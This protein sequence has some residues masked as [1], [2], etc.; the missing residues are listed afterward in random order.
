MTAP[1]VIFS[2]EIRAESNVEQVRLEIGGSDLPKGPITWGGTLRKNITRYAGDDQ[3][4]AQILGTIDEPFTLEGVFDDYWWGAIGH[5]REMKALCEKL[6]YAGALVHLEYRDEQR[7]GLFWCRLEEE[8]PERISYTI[9]FEPLYRKAPTQ[10]PLSFDLPPSDAA[11]VIESQLADMLD[12]AQNSNDATNVAAVIAGQVVSKMLEAEGQIGAALD[13]VSQVSYWSE[14]GPDLARQAR[15][16][17]SG[18]VRALGSAARRLG[19]TT[20]T[21]V[22]KADGIT[23]FAAEAWR[24]KSLLNVQQARSD[25]LSLLEQ[26]WTVFEPLGERT[27]TLR[28]GE[29]LQGL[30]FDYYG[31]WELWTVIADANDFDTDDV[32]AGTE[33]RVPRL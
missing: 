32:P 25:A 9:N 24:D 2:A 23:Q 11:T 13:I 29:T 21:V 19:N 12:Y 1:A 26:L 27:H 18:A 17:A 10:A 14:L 8:T 22:A 6:L 5:A 33:V 30:A 20:S 31:D 15:T 28:E 3:V 7:W 16:S 4:S